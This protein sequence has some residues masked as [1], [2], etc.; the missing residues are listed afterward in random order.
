MVSAGVWGKVE[1]A[2]YESRW[3][4]RG[5]GGEERAR[6]RNR[7][8]DSAHGGTLL[9]GGEGADLAQGGL[10]GL[11]LREHGF[12]VGELGFQPR[13]LLFQELVDL[14]HAVLELAGAGVERLVLA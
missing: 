7:R 11:H 5:P 9:R 10:L 8:G 12:H 14:V 3:G 13:A 2:A 1:M 4:P 6:S